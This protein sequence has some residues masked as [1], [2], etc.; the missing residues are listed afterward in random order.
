[1]VV[2]QLDKNMNKGFGTLFIVIV[3]GGIAL[4]L[5]LWVSTSGL[6]SVRGSI[7]NASSAQTKALVNACAEVALEAMRENNSYVGTSNVTI[8]G[9][10]CT[11]TVTN[12]GGSNRS[13]SVTGNIGAITRK[14]L[15]TTNA[16]NPL[17]IVS[18][19]EVE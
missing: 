3:L 19:Q 15:I 2:P 16:F 14:L 5:A 17:T 10:T 18:W 9:N 6:W 11:Y 8:S 4:A 12:T 13:V 1:M 7:N